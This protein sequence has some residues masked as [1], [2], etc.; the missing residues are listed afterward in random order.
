MSSKGV[1]MPEKKNRIGYTLALMGLGA[2]LA[3]CSGEE[4]TDAQ[5]TLRAF[6]MTGTAMS[7]TLTAIPPTATLAPTETLPPTATPTNTEVPT[8]TLTPSEVPTQ[9]PTATDTLQ[10]SFTPKP[11]ETLAPT[12]TEDTAAQATATAHTAEIFEAFETATAQ[13]QSTSTLEPTPTIFGGTVA[14]QNDVVHGREGNLNNGLAPFDEITYTNIDAWWDREEDLADQVAQGENFVGDSFWTSISNVSRLDADGNA[15]YTDDS[16]DR[17]P[18]VEYGLNQTIADLKNYK[19]VLRVLQDNPKVSDLY[20]ASVNQKDNNFGIYGLLHDRDAA[21]A[22]IAGIQYYALHPEIDRD[23]QIN[24]LLGTYAAEI[25]VLQLQLLSRMQRQTIGVSPE[26]QARRNDPNSKDASRLLGGIAADLRLGNEFYSCNVVRPDALARDEQ[27]QVNRETTYEDDAPELGAVRRST[28]R[29]FVIGGTFADT[30]ANNLGVKSFDG[31]A[32]DPLYRPAYNSDGT[33]TPEATMLPVEE[34]MLNEQMI[35][36]GYIEGVGNYIASATSI[37]ILTETG[38]QIIS[39]PP[40]PTETPRP[41]E[42][43]LPTATRPAETP[44]V[45]PSPTNTEV[46]A[47]TNVH[48]IPTSTPGQPPEVEPTVTDAP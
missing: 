29:A 13:A 20:W 34:S 42:T 3:A 43:P 17:D 39:T 21:L 28:N 31:G 8:H 47:P 35:S 36:C 32:A 7:E 41:G 40:G 45:Q 14:V 24:D 22:V 4:Q 27:D 23:I 2:S 46:V 25:R 48:I 37:V 9:T 19:N 26:E 38:V 44:V 5:A 11:T 6:S 1:C 12:A 10:P 18:E 33:A 16:V 30:D 15:I